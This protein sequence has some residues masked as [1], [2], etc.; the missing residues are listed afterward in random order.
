MKEESKGKPDKKT[1]LDDITYDVL[2]EIYPV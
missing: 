2:N 1:L